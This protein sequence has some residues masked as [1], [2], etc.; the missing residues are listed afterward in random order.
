MTV[1]NSRGPLP[2]LAFALCCSIWGSTF[3]FIRM[4]NGS[5]PPVWGAAL[6][7]SI[8]TVLFALLGLLLRRPWPARHAL[9]ATLLYGAVNFGVEPAAAVLGRAACTERTRLG[10]V[11]D[12]PADHPRCSRA[13]WAWSP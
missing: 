2:W 10:H 13:P 1:P 3:L 9:P 12:D 8:A 6:R 11:R 4:S 7:L 5:L